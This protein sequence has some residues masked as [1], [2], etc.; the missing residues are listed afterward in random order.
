MKSTHTENKAKENKKV[1]V[2]TLMSLSLAL[3]SC[4]SMQRAY[5]E[6]DSLLPPEVVPLDPGAASSMQQAEAQ[7]RA[8]QMGMPATGNGMQTAQQARQAAFDSLM[9]QGEM[10]PQLKGAPFTP[11]Q[12]TAGGS[13]PTLAS[14]AG[15]ANTQS[16][17]LS[18]QVKTTSL[19]GQDAIHKGTPLAKGLIAAAGIGMFAMSMTMMIR[20][21]SNSNRLYT[22][23]FY[24]A[25]A[26]SIPRIGSGY[27]YPSYLVG[28]G[29]R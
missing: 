18:G 27:V 23:P 29:L 12:A 20:N 7:A 3:A 4:L 28:R 15:P 2:C 10:P 26:V 1:L 21:Y 11:S 9:N 8:A 22:A 17:T 6:E 5:A 24:G 14:N 13:T 19:K 25:P 16:Q